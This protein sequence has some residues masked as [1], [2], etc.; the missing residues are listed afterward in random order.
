MIRMSIKR[1]KNIKK[2]VLYEIDLFLVDDLERTST[3]MKVHLRNLLKD[4]NIYF[5][6]VKTSKGFEIYESLSDCYN[7]NKKIKK[8]FD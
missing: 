1:S 4:E 6:S 7:E 3:E 8:R 5:L 2:L